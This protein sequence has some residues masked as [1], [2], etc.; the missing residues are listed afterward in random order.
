MRE[1]RK[2]VEQRAEWL[3]WHDLD[4][5]VLNPEIPLQVYLPPSNRT[6]LHLLATHDMLSL[7]NGIFFARV[8]PL[9]NLLY[10][11]ILALQLKKPEETKKK[12]EDQAALIEILN[13]SELFSQA[14]QQIPRSWGLNSYGSE[15]FDN[16]HLGAPETVIQPGHLLLHLV[17]PAKKWRNWFEEYLTI[18]EKHTSEFEIPLQ[19]LNLEIDVQQFWEEIPSKI[20]S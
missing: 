7:N 10:A 18:A 11:S 20:I 3:F 1:L 17:G 6:D 5:V 13:Q 2:P 8:S 15:W 4:T 16:M 19:S 12:T 14:Y 9:S